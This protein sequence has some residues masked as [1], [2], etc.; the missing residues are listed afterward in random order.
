[1]NRLFTAPVNVSVN[2]RVAVGDAIGMLARLT[3]FARFKPLKPVT[4]TP[5]ELVTVSET[6]V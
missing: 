3:V 6:V 1:M 5:F 4:T 2:V